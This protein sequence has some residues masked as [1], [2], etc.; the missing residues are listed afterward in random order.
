VTQKNPIW[1]KFMCVSDYLSNVVVV[2]KRGETLRV[3]IT[4]HFIYLS[5]VRLVT[6]SALPRNLVMFKSCLGSVP[7]NWKPK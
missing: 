2:P 1:A 7:S 4:P 6:V 5:L 3:E